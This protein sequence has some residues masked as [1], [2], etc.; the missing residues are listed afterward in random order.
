MFLEFIAY[1]QT[2]ENNKKDQNLNFNPP[3]KKAKT[4]K[5]AADVADVV[6]VKK[7]WF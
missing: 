4:A 7:N 3:P 6:K 1:K 5:G 2:H